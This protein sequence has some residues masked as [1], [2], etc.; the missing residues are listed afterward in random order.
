M[1]TTTMVIIVIV[2]TGTG[3]PLLQSLEENKRVKPGSGAGAE[4][5]VD[6]AKPKWSQDELTRCLEA[7]ERAAEKEAKQKE[8]SEKQRSQANAAATSHTTDNDVGAE[9]DSLDPNPYDNSHSQA[10]HQV[11]VNGEDLQSHMLHVNVSLTHFVQEYSYLEPGDHLSDIPLKVAELHQ[12]MLVF[13]GI[14]RVHEAGSQSC[15]EET[16]LTHSPVITTWEFC[17]AY[18]DC[19]DLMEIMGMTSGMMKHFTGI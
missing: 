10:V 17:V 19:A 5:V 8:P 12:K 3:V 16:G 1:I 2:I 4:V 18:A 7:E 11:K 6:S 13:G 9:E 14:D 15:H